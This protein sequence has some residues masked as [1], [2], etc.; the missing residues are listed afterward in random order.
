MLVTIVEEQTK[1]VIG[2]FPVVL[3][4]YGQDQTD[5]DYFNEAWKCAVEDGLVDSEKR[6][7]YVFSIQNK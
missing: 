4:I 5:Q 7:K 2:T 1:K 3:G 6:S